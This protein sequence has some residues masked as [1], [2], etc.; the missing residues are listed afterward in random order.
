M[1]ESRVRTNIVLDVHTAS[2]LYTHDTDTHHQIVLGAAAAAKAVEEYIFCY[3]VERQK[4]ERVKCVCVCYSIRSVCMDGRVIHILA[5]KRMRTRDSV[6]TM[7]HNSE[8]LF[9]NFTEN[10]HFSSK[11]TEKLFFSRLRHPKRP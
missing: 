1:E 8:C 9:E 10:V 4:R 5:Q 6:Y 2:D 11:A 3:R 7:L